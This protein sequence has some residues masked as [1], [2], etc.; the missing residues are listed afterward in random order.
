MF[1]TNITWKNKS[2]LSNWESEVCQIS[3]KAE[4]IGSNITFNRGDWL[5]VSVKLENVEIN[6]SQQLLL[7]K[8]N[9]NIKSKT[10]PLKAWNRVEGSA[11]ITILPNCDTRIEKDTAR[12]VIFN[13]PIQ[14]GWTHKCQESVDIDEEIY[15][16]MYISPADIYQA[17]IEKITPYQKILKRNRMEG[18]KNEAM[19]EL[20][21]TYEEYLNK[22]DS[23]IETRLETYYHCS[24]NV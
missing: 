2:N 20:F 15:L 12:M 14:I 23:D 18:T 7:E 16:A 19:E 8:W 1:T 9:Q 3:S 24:G 13:H 11:K 21:A 4:N 17:I 22:I 10:E 6:D 5:Q